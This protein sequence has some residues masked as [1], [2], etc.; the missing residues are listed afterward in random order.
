MT[1]HS[2]Q[3]MCTRTQ[4]STAYI[5]GAAFHGEE[6]AQTISQGL[7]AHMRDQ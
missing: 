5:Y 4:K 1:A 2:M 7:H 6:C 3:C